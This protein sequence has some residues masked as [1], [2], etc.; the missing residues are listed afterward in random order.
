MTPTAAH[1]DAIGWST[2]ELARR[3]G[4]SSKTARAWRSGRRSPPPQV[5]AWLQALAS[6]RTWG[7]LT[8]AVIAGIGPVPQEERL[9]P[10]PSC[11]ENSNA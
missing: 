11:A 8:E 10:E 1:L 3:L 7:P 5:I 2:T 4:T 6:T 9:H